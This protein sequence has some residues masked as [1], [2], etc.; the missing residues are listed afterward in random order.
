MGVA[1]IALPKNPIAVLDPKRSEFV[2]Y[3]HDY[4]VAHTILQLGSE[5]KSTCRSLATF[6]EKY[7]V[8]FEFLARLFFL[9]FHTA[10]K[11][12]Q[13]AATIATMV[14]GAIVTYR[15]K[16]EVEVPDWVDAFVFCRETELS[17]QME[18]ARRQVTA[19]EVEA[20]QWRGF[21]GV[22]TASGDLLKDRILAIVNAFFGVKT[23]PLD[24]GR[25][26][27]KILNDDSNVL[28]I[29]EVK[30]T[31]GGIKREHINQVDSHRER[32]GLTQETPGILIINN[33]MTISELSA[34]LATKVP[35][36]QIVHARRLNCLIVRTVDLLF[37]MR[38]LENNENRK[39]ELTSLLLAGGGWLRS[40]E[41]GYEIVTQ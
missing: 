12:D 34:R 5:H 6:D 37:L 17:T 33:E 14:A 18:A 15:Q 29:A 25:E 1:R 32:N 28:A 31:N 36:E 35:A 7:I 11:D 2:A 20:E 39:A 9:P 13:T 4:G 8:G 10:S 27:F 3:L 19:L 24:E 38:H 21:K 40:G 22:L 26:D 23:D 16:R 41:D 30:G